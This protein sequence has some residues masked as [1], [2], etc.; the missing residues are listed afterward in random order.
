M[1]E[2]EQQQ[3]YRAVKRLRD[4]PTEENLWEVILIYQNITFKTYSGLPFSYEIRRGRNGAYT[5]ELWI[6]RRENSKSLAWSFVRLAFEKINEIGAVIER[7]KALGDIRGVSYI[8][9]NL[10]PAWFDQCSGR[11]TGKDAKQSGDALKKG[12]SDRE[13]KG[14]GGKFEKAEVRSNPIY[15]NAR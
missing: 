15:K 6:D 4:N 10:L 12:Q 7:S 2:A 14:V 1:E 3:R 13:S 11:G 8:Y 5:K 9:G